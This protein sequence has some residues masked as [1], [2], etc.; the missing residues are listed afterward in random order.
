M[1]EDQIPLFF[2]GR[3]WLLNKTDA[4]NFHMGPKIKVPNKY[5]NVLCGPEYNNLMVSL[6]F[7]GILEASA[8]VDI[9]L[10]IG[11]IARHL[12]KYFIQSDIIS[13]RA[14]YTA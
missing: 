5:S 11:K 3:L 1:D 6:K 10:N 13:S 7:K 9:I 2:F 4:E 8:P 14:L 12:H